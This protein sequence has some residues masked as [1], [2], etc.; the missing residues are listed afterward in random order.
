[1]RIIRRKQLDITNHLYESSKVPE[2]FDGYR[3]VLLSDLHCN[4]LGT[5]S[6]F[7]LSKIHDI[8]PNAV[9]M[10]GDMLSDD[11]KNFRVTEKLI[12]KLVSHYP[13]FYSIGNHEQKLE[14]NP[15]LIYKYEKFKSFLNTM[16]AYYLDNKS[17]YITRG[18]SSI[19]VTG[20][21]I[22]SL[23]YNKFWQKRKASVDYITELIGEK[24]FE[25]LDILIAHNPD[26]FDTY[27]KWGADIVLS[28]HV[29][30]GLIVLPKLGGVIAPTLR[31]FPKYDFGC[32]SNGNAK[33]YLSRGLGSHTLPIRIFNKPE[34]LV[35]TLHRC[36]A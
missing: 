12:D 14:N 35:I 8:R 16:G 32:F 36:D 17:V 24:E 4:E 2:E 1:M 23:Y 6:C 27:S 22:D 34:I 21:G 11:G 13:V 29:H 10:A 33:M 30:G 18:D 31:L 28:G 3:I 9:M 19:R 15:D 7:L 25:T 20:I 5:D 26:Y